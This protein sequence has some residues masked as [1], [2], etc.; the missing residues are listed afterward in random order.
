[1][2]ADFECEDVEKALEYFISTCKWS[3]VKAISLVSDCY[4]SAYPKNELYPIAARLPPSCVARHAQWRLDRLRSSFFPRAVKKV[5]FTLIHVPENEICN[6]QF[7]LL[8]N[9]WK[10]RPFD[11]LN[12]SQDCRNAEKLNIC[13]YMRCGQIADVR[14]GQPQ[15][16]HQ[17]MTGKMR[18]GLEHW[19]KSCLVL[20]FLTSFCSSWNA[21]RVHVNSKQSK[22]FQDSFVSVKKSSL[23]PPQ[24]KLK[25]YCLALTLVLLF[26]FFS[27]SVGSLKASELE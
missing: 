21:L 25:L 2:N 19:C 3:V 23:S 9:I 11:C 7:N 24:P 5:S 20:L 27:P 8:A 26:C 10:E 18:G 22:H 15:N 4:I 12:G 6:S 17:V 14:Q 13:A 1:M 16:W